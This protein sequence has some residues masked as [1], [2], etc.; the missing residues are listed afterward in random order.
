[1]K[2][3]LKTKIW[4]LVIFVALIFNVL[5]VTVF[6]EEIIDATDENTGIEGDV[7]GD[8]VEGEPG[9]EDGTGD[10]EEIIDYSKAVDVS[11][12]EELELMLGAGERVI[13]ITADFMLDRTFCVVS[14]VII[15]ADEVHT[16][17]RAPGFG[18]DIFLVGECQDGTPTTGSVELSL[19]KP[20]DE[21]SANITIDGNADNMIADVVG[22]VIFVCNGSRADLYSSLTVKNCKKV[23]NERTLGEYGVSYPPRV[24][25]AVAIVAKGAK[26]AIYGGSYVNNTVN[27]IT[28]SS[29]DEGNLSSQGGVIYNYGVLDV[30]GGTFEN[31]HAGRG[32]VFYNYRTMNLYNAVIKN[33][34]ASSLGGAIYVPNSTSAFTYI[35]E[36]NDVVASKV[37]FEGNTSDTHAGAI[38][39]PVYMTVKNTTFKNNVAVGSGGAIFGTSAEMLVEYSEFVGNSAGT[40]GGAVYVTST[41]GEEDVRELEIINSTFKENTAV[42]RGGAVYASET[43]RVYVAKSNFHSNS[44]T[45][46]GAVYLTG[47][48][49]EINVAEMYDNGATS[50]GGAIAL[51]ST[52]SALINGVTAGRNRTDSSGGFIYATNSTFELY[53]SSV[54]NNAAATHGGGVIAYTGAGASIYNT[55][56]EGNEAG[57]NGGAVAVYPEDK[58]STVLHSCTFTGNI[59]GELGGAVWASIQCCNHLSQSDTPDIGGV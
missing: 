59:G 15:F 26:M 10:A 35:G 5:P 58:L 2:A 42:T 49:L 6:A 11:T 38:Y 21:E 4:C 22:S 31:N 55:V 33:N 8:G 56:F 39:N 20:G 51:Y 16:L 3:S 18:K 43:A 44:A 53:N 17:T 14:D 32:G 28:D 1:M 34:S 9:D 50:N 37:L 23:G 47:S 54:V 36:E 12:A 25:G 27:D 57:K 30:Y 52:S 7:D 29:T 46:G 48:E 40:N 45:Y 19:G 24:G 41:N 13:R